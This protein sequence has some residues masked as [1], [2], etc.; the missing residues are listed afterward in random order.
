MSE[1][2]AVELDTKMEDG[3]GVMMR[4]VSATEP[5]SAGLDRS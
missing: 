4:W 2:G 1:L 5:I 3:S